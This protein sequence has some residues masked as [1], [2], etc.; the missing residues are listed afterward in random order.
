MSI[1]ENMNDSEPLE[2][3]DL[4]FEGLISSIMEIFKIEG[5]EDRVY[6][7]NF[8]IWFAAEYRLNPVSFLI[9]EGETIGIMFPTIGEESYEDVINRYPL[10]MDEGQ[11]HIRVEFVKEV[12]EK[13]DILLN[14]FI[15]TDDYTGLNT[16]LNALSSEYDRVITLINEECVSEEEG[17][18]E[19]T[20]VAEIEAKTLEDEKRELIL[21]CQRL[22]EEVMEKFPLTYK[23]ELI[24]EMTN[25]VAFEMNKFK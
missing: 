7:K 14:S 8:V 5:C 2:F 25:Q 16:W 4:E 1:F 19:G 15:G 24:A 21:K 12:C 13:I 3:G 23:L 11:D 20:E 9:P 6:T 17:V 22:I 10:L 18:S